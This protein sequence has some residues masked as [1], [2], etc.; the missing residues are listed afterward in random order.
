MV[1]NL[2]HNIKYANRAFAKPCALIFTM[3]GAVLLG[4][5]LF[6][7]IKDHMEASAYDKVNGTIVYQSAEAVTTRIEYTID[8]QTYSHSGSYYNSLQKPG[9][10]VKIL[11]NPSDPNDVHESF[12]IFYVILLVVGGIFSV[13][14]ILCLRATVKFENNLMMLFRD[15]AKVMA[16]VEGFENDYSYQINNKPSMV[17]IARGSYDDKIYKSNP[18]FTKH[19]ISDLIDTKVTVH[20]DRD[21]PTNY[22]VEIL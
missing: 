12:T 8:G 14:G 17:L 20:I 11:V 10:N 4:L 16:I 19:D 3:V 13:V 22:F 1:I 18:F 5:C 21:D 7:T 2:R 6:F 9:Q 15:G